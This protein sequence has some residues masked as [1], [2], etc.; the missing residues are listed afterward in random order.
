M[1]G[2]K[3]KGVQEGLCQHLPLGSRCNPTHVAK[4]DDRD[5]RTSLGETHEGKPARIWEK[6]WTT[7]TQ[8]VVVE[9]EH[10]SRQTLMCS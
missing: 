9:R 8:L 3:G 1:E 2:G 10:C 4:E 6:A 7:K 5:V